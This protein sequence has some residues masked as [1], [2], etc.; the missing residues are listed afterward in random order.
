M[1]T[2]GTVRG[3][4]GLSA[5]DRTWNRAAEQGRVRTRPGD[6]ALAAVILADSLVANGGVFHCIEVLSRDELDAAL[7]AYAYFGLDHVAEVFQRTAATTDDDADETEA[8]LDA[9]Y[10]NAMDDPNGTLSQGSGLIRAF[11][12]DYR[13]HPDS[14][15]PI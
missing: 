2:R 5:A 12:D 3:V 1:K 10:W 9:E 4:S 7:A 11:E 13:A 8:A 14:Y 6:R 15:E